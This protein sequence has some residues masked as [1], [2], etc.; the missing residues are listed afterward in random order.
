M[1]VY[2]KRGKPEYPEKNL[3]EQGRTQPTYNVDAGIWT[4]AIL[5]GDEC[6]HP[7]T[8]YFAPE[9]VWIWGKPKKEKLLKN[10]NNNNVHT[11]V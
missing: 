6:S 11:Y 1:L 8:H 9:H 5:V 2:E 7:C 4:W 10:L 3:S